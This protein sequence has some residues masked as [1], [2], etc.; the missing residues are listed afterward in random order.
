M[1]ARLSRASASPGGVGEAE[2]VDIEDDGRATVWRSWCE[3]R[4]GRFGRALHDDERDAIGRAVD[5]AAG[6]PIPAPDPGAV[7]TPDGT[8]DQISGSSLPLVE[9]D[10]YDEGPTGWTDLVA[11]LRGLLDALTEDPVAAIEV[12]I[13]VATPGVRLRH[14]GTEPVQ[15][16]L[17]DV[18]VEAYLCASDDSTI[19]STSATTSSPPESAGPGWVHEIP[20]ALAAPVDDQYLYLFVEL[21]LGVNDGGGLQRAHVTRSSS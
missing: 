4:A 14:I 17:T 3:Q 18:Y 6:H 20:V 1:I 9:L 19:Q 15:V 8:T 10:R 16:G 2:S 11:Q 7:V 12:E 13:D 5:E 21:D